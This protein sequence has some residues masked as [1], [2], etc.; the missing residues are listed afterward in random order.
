[1]KQKIL[2]LKKLVKNLFGILL[3]PRND[4]TIKA[5]W[6]IVNPSFNLLISLHNIEQ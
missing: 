4:L 1:M 5:S 6:W 3:R 2:C